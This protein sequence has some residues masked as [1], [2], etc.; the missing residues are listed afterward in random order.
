[1]TQTKQ[2]NVFYGYSRENPR[3]LFE[4]DFVPGRN[5]AIIAAKINFETPTESFKSISDVNTIIHPN[6]LN[7]KV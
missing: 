3:N 2:Y 6:E 5:L 1:M 4:I 7:C